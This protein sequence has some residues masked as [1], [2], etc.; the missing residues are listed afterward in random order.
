LLTDEGALAEAERAYAEIY[1]RVPASKVDSQLAA[2]YLSLWGP[3]LVK[4]GRYAE[5]EPPLREARER[6]YSAGLAKDQRMLTVLSALAEVCD[7][8][9]RPEEAAQWRAKLRELEAATRP[10]TRPG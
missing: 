2:R 6:L 5:A 7:R 9:N 1:R 3:C 4:L 10:A 8:T